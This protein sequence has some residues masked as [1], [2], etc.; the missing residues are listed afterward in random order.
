MIEIDG[1]KFSKLPF[2]IRKQGD[3][4]APDG[5]VLSHFKKDNIEDY[6]MFW[7]DAN[8]KY[9]RWLLF[10]VNTESL[11]KYFSKEITLYDILYTNRDNVVYIIDIDDDINYKRVLLTQVDKLPQEYL[12]GRNSF[13]SEKYGS[14]YANKI[15]SL[16]K[17]VVYKPSLK[18][19]FNNINEPIHFDIRFGKSIFLID[20]APNKENEK[21]KEV[22]KQ[23]RSNERYLS[24]FN[25]LTINNLSS[26]VHVLTSNTNNNIF[27]VFEE[28]TNMKYANA[29][30][31]DE[32]LKKYVRLISEELNIETKGKKTNTLISLIVHKSKNH[33]DNIHISKQEKEKILQDQTNEEVLTKI[34]RNFKFSI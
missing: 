6:F 10:E 17:D 19:R 4:L 21:I 31:S 3:I 2:K 15:A 32:L 12:P 5:P 11:S 22:I 1:L 20:N 27:F 14:V 33:L 18:S 30:F 9:N 23:I 16:Y 7:V 29:L 34:K 28:L 13:Y 25:F 24:H 26:S 8:E